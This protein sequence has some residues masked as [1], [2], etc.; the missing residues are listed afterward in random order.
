VAD[1][2]IFDGGGREPERPKIEVRRATMGCT[3][4]FI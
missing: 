3:A 1:L 2:E 4:F